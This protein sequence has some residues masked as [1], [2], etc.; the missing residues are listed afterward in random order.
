MVGFEFYA[1]YLLMVTIMAFFSTLMVLII[2]D[3]LNTVYKSR[4]KQKELSDAFERWKND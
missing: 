1:R 2:F 3:V 4:K